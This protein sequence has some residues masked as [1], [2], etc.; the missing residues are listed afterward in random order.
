MS[1]S[2]FGDPRFQDAFRN[3]EQAV[4]L[5]RQ[6]QVEEADKIFARL[7]KKNPEYFD[8]LHFY[9]LFKYQQGQ[10]ADA[11]KLVSRATKLN[12]RSTNALNSLGVILGRLKR[13]AEALASFEAALKLAPDHVQTLSNRCNSLNELGRYDEA[14]KSSERVLAIDPN[15]SEVYVPRGAA[16]IRAHCYPEALESYDR[17]V[18]LNPGSAMAWVGLGHVYFELK[19]YGEAS[20]A[21]ER[22][23]ALKS[24]LEQAWLGRGQVLFE[25]KRYEEALSDYDKA[26][27][28]R[29]DFG[30]DSLRFSAKLFVCDWKNFQIER[31][32]V[33]AS[34]RT[35]KTEVN[36]FMFLAISA[37]PEEQLQCARS[38]IAAK[39]P[40]SKTPLRQGVSYKHDKIRVG[41][42]SA[43]FRFHAVSALVAG[44]FENHDKSRFELTGVSI[45]PDD[46]S[47]I[48]RRISASFDQF[49]E[50]ASLSDEEIAAQM[51]AKEIDILVDLTGITQSARTGIFARRPSPV[52]VN[53][54]GYP[55]TMG[56]DYMDYIVADRTLVPDTHHRYYSE[57]IVYLPDTY[58][59]NDNKRRIS[60]RAF[61]RAECGLPEQGFV[62]CC[63][64]NNYKILPDVFD[65][66]MQIL[67]KVD[68]SV[69]WLLEDNSASS[70]N[71]KKEAEARGVNANRL[72]FAKR[73]PMTEH[74]ARHRM[75]DLFL[76]TLPY[77]AHTT[78]SDAL[79]AGLPLLTHI[80]EAFAGRVAASL[81][82]AVDMPELITSTQQE[83][84]DRAV[85]LA[86]SRDKLA[87]I[88]QKLGQNR[89]E[90]PLFNTQLF[91]RHIESA[92][93]AMYER[94]RSGLL[95]ETID[96]AS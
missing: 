88:R 80:G 83:Y 91:T 17:A 76:D 95:P 8:A 32:K 25:L 22:A 72:V 54:L 26:L 3:L 74:L 40:P 34:V 68:G 52:Q 65:C 13:H 81:L 47:E 38:W 67:K 44:L 85:E 20:A 90:K 4:T 16:L 36:P 35:R 19:R 93:Q 96:V 11:L 15:Y 7:V 51:R 45:M 28:I 94:S 84:A 61:T 6:G 43:D 10:L 21:Y 53:F 42:I 50:G 18:K 87:A 9:G 14:I 23:L 2:P 64:N 59:V 78:A 49:I 37:S 82:H 92:Y 73:M 57:K 33:A 12:P 66:W 60:D 70:K 48:R 75:A 1:N 5:Q 46:Q 41:Y 27:A 30:T 77:N 62:F 71:L 24:D 31:A 58:Q 86:A 56:A 89:L 39:Y 79:W 63:F 29:A 55:G 69:L